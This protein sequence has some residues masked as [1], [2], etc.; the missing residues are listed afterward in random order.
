[1]AVSAVAEV[2]SKISTFVLVVV[3]ARMLDEAEFGAFAYA[4]AFSLLLVSLAQWGFDAVLERDGST[5]PAHLPRLIAE[6]LWWR[7]VIAVPLF[8]VAAA[9]QW[10][11]RPTRASAV[12]V[13]L[14]MIATLVDSY[15]EVGRSI[16]T[17][18]RNQAGVATAQVVQRGTAALV[19]LA[20]LAAGTGLMGLAAGYLIGSVAGGIGVLISTRRLRV[21]W[22]PRSV[23]RAGL[24]A[25]GR[26]SVSVGLAAICSVI[27]LRIGAVLLGWWKSE[28]ALA[29]FM[30]AFRLLETVLFVSWA[31][32]RAAFPVMS[33]AR[34][35]GQVRASLE[36]AVGVVALVYVP[37]AA[38]VLADAPSILDLLFGSPYGETAAGAL[39]WLSVA[40][41]VYGVAHLCSFALL[42]RDQHGRLLASSA[43]GAAGAALGSLVLI[44][45]FGPA[46]AAAAVTLS[47][48]LASTVQFS[49]LRSVIGPVRILAPLALPLLIAAPTTI[50]LALV[51]L[52]VL[53][54]SS[55][56]AVVFFLAWLVSARRNDAGVASAYALIRRHP[57]SS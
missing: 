40:P 42:A 8:V 30:V 4:I 34:D 47:L 43:I 29:A 31:M 11:A 21:G 36:Q 23:T 27:M 38:I 12:A 5:D 56:F 33:A 2:A 35:H 46:G 57:V 55:A 18:C 53:L 16:A 24:A 52:P 39:R 6:N 13:L 25:M 15:S 22:A 14:V 41:L 50:G 44:P 45:A 49:L 54:E 19:G 32:R 7:T 9:T 26:K 28:E 48:V 10:F 37:F 3:A 20:A 1:M 51:R 17:A